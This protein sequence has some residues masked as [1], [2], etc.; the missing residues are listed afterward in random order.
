MTMQNIVTIEP[1][2]LKEFVSSALERASVPAEDAAIISDCLVDADM[3]GIPS[4]GVSR[5]PTYIDTFRRGFNRNKP[6]IEVHR[7]GQATAVVD[8][9]DGI[10]SLIAVRG[11]REAITL[12]FESGIGMVAVRR[13]SPFGHAGY[14]ASLAAASG[15]VGIVLS[16][17]PPAV[18]PFGGCQPILGTNPIAVAA[19]GG[20]RPDFLLDMS[21]SVIARGWLRLAARNNE[22]IPQG[23]ALTADGA[24]ARTAREAMDGILL[25]FGQH[26]GSG[27][28]MM[29]DLVAGV[30]TGAG[31]GESVRSMYVPGETHANVGHAL[32]AIRISAFLDPS[33]YE[34]R[35]TDWYDRLKAT[36]PA[37]GNDAVMIPG[38]SSAAIARKHQRDGISLDSE[39]WRSLQQ[40]AVNLGIPVVTE[41]RLCSTDVLEVDSGIPR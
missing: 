24:P 38:E 41:K 12:A 3:R 8:G 22:P 26:K 7:T 17:A 14:F 2:R 18:A 29:I 16:N 20:K 31:F 33:E 11:M 39:T 10:G 23:L 34:R 5:L 4:H 32:I 30:L 1:D 27:I 37:R 36:S 35:Y 6:L 13:S 25:P 40:L 9:D 19:P 15:C 28:A 21:T